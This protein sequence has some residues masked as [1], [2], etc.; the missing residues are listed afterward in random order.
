MPTVLD[1][2]IDYADYGPKDGGVRRPRRAPERRSMPNAV[3]SMNEL[4][5]AGRKATLVGVTRRAP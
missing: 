5:F 4:H 2:M 1:L 3:I